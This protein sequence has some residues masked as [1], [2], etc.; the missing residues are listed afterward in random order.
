LAKGIIDACVIQKRDIVVPITSIDPRSILIILPQ[1]D[2]TG[3]RVVAARIEGELRASPELRRL[4]QRARVGVIKT[5]PPSLEGQREDGPPALRA[6]R[7]LEDAI[8]SYLKQPIGE[9]SVH[10]ERGP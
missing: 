8:T 10:G 6:A 3:T 9:R 2:D 5:A 4:G 7:L 1:A